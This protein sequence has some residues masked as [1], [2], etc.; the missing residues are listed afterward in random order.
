MTVRYGRPAGL[1]AFR[2]CECPGCDVDVYAPIAAPARCTA[3]GGPGYLEI[4]EPDEYGLPRT[5]SSGGPP[6]PPEPRPS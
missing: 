5:A 6:P 2:R 3:H 1:D 4:R